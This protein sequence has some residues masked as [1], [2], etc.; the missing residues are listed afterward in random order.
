MSEREHFLS[1]TGSER[2][3]ATPLVDR[4]SRREA[5]VAAGS[6]SALSPHELERQFPSIARLLT[7]TPADESE[8]LAVL[9]RQSALLTDDL[10][11]LGSGSK[12]LASRP[13][14]LTL[15]TVTAYQ[16]SELV[17]INE[18][19]H[20]AMHVIGQGY[21]SLLLAAQES[22]RAREQEVR[23]LE[24]EESAHSVNG[25]NVDHIRFW[26]RDHSSP[27]VR[28][29]FLD[30]TGF[31]SD[32]ALSQQ[33]ALT[34]EEF[35]RILDAYWQV[36]KNPTAVYDLGLSIQA[37]GYGAGWR[38]AQLGKAGFSPADGYGLFNEQV[39]AFNSNKGFSLR[40]PI[41]DSHLYG[42][43]GTM[44]AQF[45]EHI[46][47]MFNF[48]KIDT[49]QDIQS[50]LYIQGI[51]ESVLHGYGLPGGLVQPL[52]LEQ[53]VQVL[54]EY[55]R[56][57]RERG[58]E[59]IPALGDCRIDTD[60]G[61]FFIGD[62]VFG[63]AVWE[64][65]GWHERPDWLNRPRE[66]RRDRLESTQC[67]VKLT[68][69]LFLDPPLES[70]RSPV[71]VL[72]EGGIVALH[73][74][75]TS[76]FRVVNQAVSRIRHLPVA[77]V[78]QL[79]LLGKDLVRGTAQLGQRIA[80]RGLSS[81]LRA[82]FQS[83]VGEQQQAWHRRA[84]SRRREMVEAGQAWLEDRRHDLERQYQ[85]LQELATKV[86]CGEMSEEQNLELLM[87]MSA[88]L[89]SFHEETAEHVIRVTD[90]TLAL[91]RRLQQDTQL[92]DRYEALTQPGF[93]SDLQTATQLH[94]LGKIA[95]PQSVVLCRS[96]FTARQAFLMQ[97]HVLLSERI[98]LAQPSPRLRRVALVAGGHHEKY[99]GSG[100]PRGLIG[101]QIPIGAQVM[102]V[103]DVFDAIG[104]NAV[105]RDYQDRIRSRPEILRIFRND[106][107][108]GQFNPRIVIELFHLLNTRQPLTAEEQ[109]SL[110]D[111]VNFGT[112]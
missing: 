65:D 6:T 46:L 41:R 83:T 16:L 17:G 106:T 81:G 98:L 30:K 77:T 112:L 8:Q 45:E 53:P 89:G 93:L 13:F 69:G 18:R 2:G 48:P 80:E 84:E 64:D 42:Q 14:D 22:L 51:L 79:Q 26:L 62:Q 66:R 99:D 33:R 109:R 29:T 5:N 7:P 52:I 24:T 20:A 49:N 72:A 58:V 43:F 88:L 97:T 57:M 111:V 36:L 15:L 44:T 67:L 40:D 87:R 107:L 100:Y 4:R 91:A 35:G 74:L 27:E 103:G 63:Y 76:R 96:R 19:V 37:Y 28:Q 105:Q 3:D 68:R 11:D 102:A 92:L 104:G 21:R 75:P 50:R 108:D 39:I 32:E 85:A 110:D 60:S 12:R 47:D 55:L 23:A 82:A 31:A 94:D 78:T 71:V 56:G 59:G 73:R 101:D 1:R 9:R 61:D 90:I 95:V 10:P 34:L 38:A 86:A 25:T 70:R 54:I